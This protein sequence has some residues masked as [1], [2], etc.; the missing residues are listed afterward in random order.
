VF[1]LMSRYA[2]RGDTVNLRDSI[3]RAVRLSI[4]EGLATGVGLFILAGPIIT[5]IYARRKFTVADAE[6]AAFV[7][8]MYVLGMWAYCSYQIL[9]RA[10]YA[11]KDT[12]TPLRVSCCLAVVNLAMLLSLMW[13][14]GFGPGAFGLSTSITFS[15]NTLILIWILRKRLGLLGGRKIAISI[16][17]SLIA[18]GA[19][20]GVVYALRWYMNGMRNLLILAVCIP[21]GAAVFL[22][23]A[24]LL[25]APELKEL[26]GPGLPSQQDEPSATG[27]Q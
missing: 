12:R 9:A 4:M 16:V 10:F 14:P 24:W 6:Q 2:S 1:P 22:M 23:V 13:I 20:A 18:C 7:L 27:L 25:R 17:R 11:C 5:T 15:L 8:Q 3:N 19:M 21:T 26:L